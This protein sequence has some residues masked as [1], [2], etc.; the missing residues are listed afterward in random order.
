MTILSVD[1]KTIEAVLSVW[2][3]GT[4]LINTSTPCWSETS[5]AP[6][7]HPYQQPGG[8]TR[9]LSSSLHTVCGVQAPARRRVCPVSVVCRSP[10]LTGLSPRVLF[11]A[12]GGPPLFLPL[13]PTIARER[14]ASE[15]L[16]CQQVNIYDPTI[17]CVVNNY[18]EYTPQ[19]TVQFY[20]YI[21]KFL[22]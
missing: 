11:P 21:Y 1:T 19:Q 16:W 14:T 20:I 3:V 2:T 5:E 13:I 22:P 6:I 9:L 15:R 7:M 10:A 12:A 18:N 4:P 8:R 17:D